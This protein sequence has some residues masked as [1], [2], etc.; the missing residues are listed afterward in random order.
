MKKAKKSIDALKVRCK[1]RIDNAKNKRF[2]DIE[3]KLEDL[4]SLKDRVASIQEQRTEILNLGGETIESLKSECDK[5]ASQKEEIKRKNDEQELRLTSMALKLKGTEDLIAKSTSEKSEIEEAMGALRQSLTNLED[6]TASYKG[7]LQKKID[8]TAEYSKKTRENLQATENETC[9]ID[10][11]KDRNSSLKSLTNSIASGVA[12][13]DEFH[14]RK[15]EKVNL[16]SGQFVDMDKL[17]E[18]ISVMDQNFKSDM[19]LCNHL[20]KEVVD[21]VCT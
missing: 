8:A 16:M 11:G 19:D 14:V 6:E 18:E 1:E 20:V 3:L 5:L 9:E 4:A 15:S 2:Q 10:V 7:E 17:K 12:K 21:T 13:L